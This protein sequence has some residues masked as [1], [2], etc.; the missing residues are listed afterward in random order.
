MSNQTA[1]DLPV[2]LKEPGAEGEIR[3][4][5]QAFFEVIVIAPLFSSELAS[6]SG[7]DVAVYVAVDVALLH[8]FE[9]KRIVF[10]STRKRHDL[11]KILRFT[12]ARFNQ[13]GCTNRKHWAWQASINLCLWS[14][15]S[16][17]QTLP[18]FVT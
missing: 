16:I 15:A 9:I 17:S 6:N 4:R 10:P 7:F 18:C 14:M 11:G 12:V 3:I 5:T 1:A 13:G 8:V 2:Y